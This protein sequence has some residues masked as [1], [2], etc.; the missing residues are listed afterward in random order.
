M[1]RRPNWKYFSKVRN[2]PPNKKRENKI[3][4]EEGL[5]GPYK[6]HSDL[7]LLKRRLYLVLTNPQ[8]LQFEIET[9]TQPIH[10]QPAL[11]HLSHS[12][13]L[14]RWR[15]VAWGDFHHFGCSK[16]CLQRPKSDYLKLAW[17]QGF[18]IGD[19]ILTFCTWIFSSETGVFLFLKKHNLRLLS[20]FAKEHREKS[21]RFVACCFWVLAS[22]LGKEKG[23]DIS[24]TIQLS[25]PAHPFTISDGTHSALSSGLLFGVLK[26]APGLLRF[27]D[28]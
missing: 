18:M 24:K 21:G 3:N 7:F 17:N 2:L 9:D 4:R 1:K 26:M 20:R 15:A 27:Q 19:C 28:A 22:L 16:R 14:P 12:S 11:S 25:S 5:E 10:G 8:V 13:V 23:P 6:I